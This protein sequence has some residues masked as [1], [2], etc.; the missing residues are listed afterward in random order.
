MGRVSRRKVNPEVEE[1]YFEIFWNLL[2]Q[3]KSPT[4]I[5]EFLASLLSYTEQVMLT[6]RLAIAVLLT[7]GYN[8]EEIDRVLKVSKSTVGTVHKQILVGAVGYKKAVVKI[9]RQEKIDD[10]LDKLE[11]ISLKISRPAPYGSLRFEN[12]SN[13]GKSLV[14]RIRKRSAI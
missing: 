1:R 11:E 3:L 14:K 12:K 4:E 6:K 9:L 8:Y 5:K 13:A 7:R 10:F 2:A